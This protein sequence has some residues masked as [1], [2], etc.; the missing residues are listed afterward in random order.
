MNA[1]VY[2]GIWEDTKS[3]SEWTSNLYLQSIQE[4]EIWQTT[5]YTSVL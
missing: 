2:M 4:P 1:Y 3:K 5:A